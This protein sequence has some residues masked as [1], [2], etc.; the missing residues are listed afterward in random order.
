MT[1]ICL[2]LI[3]TDTTGNIWLVLFVL[4]KSNTDSFIIPYI[5]NK[6]GNIRQF[7]LNQNRISLLS[8]TE[9]EIIFC[10]KFLNL[11]IIISRYKPATIF[12]K[13]TTTREQLHGIF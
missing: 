1:D 8:K 13:P 7:T 9:K 12:W 2:K 5:E 4:E 3:E 10:A 6:K 11:N